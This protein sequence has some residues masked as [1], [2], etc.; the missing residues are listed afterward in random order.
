MEVQYGKVRSAWD[1]SA[2]LRHWIKSTH[3]Y[4]HMRS[5]LKI[6][7][8]MLKVM[9]QEGMWKMGQF[10]I[11]T[12]H[13]SLV[14]KYCTYCTYTGTHTTNTTSV[15]IPH[16][17]NHWYTYCTYYNYKYYTGTDTTDMEC[18]PQIHTSINDIIVYLIF[19]LKL[20]ISIIF[21]LT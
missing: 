20:L 14:H 21:R 18:I 8:W 10:I 5:V 3:T 2:N 6:M 4:H 11:H 16:T 9:V 7:A 17:I 15:Q 1:T 19:Q 12:L 13:H